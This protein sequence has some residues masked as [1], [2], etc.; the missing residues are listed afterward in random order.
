MTRIRNKCN[1]TLEDP[2]EECGHGYAAQFDSYEN[3]DADGN[4]GCWVPVTLCRKCGNDI[5]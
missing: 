2:C 4:R 3:D 1:I 5:G